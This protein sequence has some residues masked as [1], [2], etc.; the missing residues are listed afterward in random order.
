MSD[1]FIQSKILRSISLLIFKYLSKL[2]NSDKKKIFINSMPKA[3]THLIKL[4]VTLFEGYRN[5]FQHI[6][7]NEINLNTKKYVNVE[8]FKLSKKRLLSKLKQIKN[9]QVV[10][11][12]LPYNNKLE[13]LLLKNNF[14]IIY[15]K[16][17]TAEILVSNFYYIQALKR[18][19][20]HSS[21]VNK[22]NNNEQRMR[23]LIEG[24]Y[25]K[26]NYRSD[27]IKMRIKYFCGWEKKNK[28]KLIIDFKDISLNSKRKRKNQILKKIAFFLEV[29]GDKKIIQKINDKLKISKTP[30]LRSGKSLKKN[31]E[32]NKIFKRYNII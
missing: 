22:F 3:G 28:N 8:N 19:Y 9:G 20:L 11:G 26:N 14:K 4:I 15:I 17:N 32:F 6:D 13:S 2:G 25:F 16:R 10:T 29:N 7:I 30:T 23:A 31:L 21:F 27:S 1:N 12:H 18:H 24:Y 5:S